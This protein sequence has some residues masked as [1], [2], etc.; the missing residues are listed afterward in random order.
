MTE[1][2]GR[3]E[4]EAPFEQARLDDDVIEEIAGRVPSAAELTS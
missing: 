2:L 4:I 1:L 3:A